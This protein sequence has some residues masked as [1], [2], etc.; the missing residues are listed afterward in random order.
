MRRRRGGGV[1]GVLIRGRL[2]CLLAEHLP[3]M[4]VF[5]TTT[6]RGGR[7]FIKINLGRRSPEKVGGDE[8]LRRVGQCCN[9]Q[10]SRRRSGR[11]VQLQILSPG[12]AA[13]HQQLVFEGRG[14][15]LQILSPGVGH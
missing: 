11:G 2:E 3:G 4:E 14:V 5:S 1:L 12:G 9:S 13:A 15:Q 8:E 7:R 10:S 6:L